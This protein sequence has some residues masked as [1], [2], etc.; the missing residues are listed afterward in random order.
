MLFLRKSKKVRRIA[1][2]GFDLF[3]AITEIVIG[4][5]RDNHSAF[6]AACHFESHAIVVKFL[7]VFPAHPV[8][9]LAFGGDLQVWQTQLSLCDFGEVRREDDATGVASPVLSDPT[10]RRSPE[11]KGRRH[12]QRYFQ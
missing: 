11:G 12:F 6:I 1:D 7:L 5:D 10:L 2:L 9:A 4:D 8:A 3:L